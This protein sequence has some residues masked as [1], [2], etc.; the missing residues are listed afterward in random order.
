MTKN[1]V[2]RPSQKRK[3][4]GSTAYQACFES[5]AHPGITF[6]FDLSKKNF[7]ICSRCRKAREKGQHV[8]TIQITGQQNAP[9]FFRQNPDE[10]HHICLQKDLGMSTSAVKINLFTTKL[11]VKW[12]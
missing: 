6:T 4:D 11:N 10:I 7:Y 3:K 9:S 12:R 1:V 2:W 5:Q 8:P